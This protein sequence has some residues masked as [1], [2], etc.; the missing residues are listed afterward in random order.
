MTVGELFAV[1]MG[2]G[3]VLVSIGSLLER[4]RRLQASQ[5]G[6]GQRIGELE[7]MSARLETAH[8]LAPVL[9]R[10]RLRRWH[11]RMSGGVLKPVARPNEPEGGT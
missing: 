7:D 2:A 8:E 5:K 1:G 6:M 4:L 3:G 11:R 9:R 10:L